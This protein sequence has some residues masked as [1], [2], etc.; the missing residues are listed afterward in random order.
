MIDHSGCTEWL[1]AGAS[2]GCHAFCGGCA[3]GRIQGNEVHTWGILPGRGTPHSRHPAVR[4]RASDGCGGLSGFGVC[5]RPGKS[6]S[7]TAPWRYGAQRGDQGRNA[8]AQRLG[9]PW[10]YDGDERRRVVKDVYGN[11][12]YT[13]VGLPASLHHLGF[14][15]RIGLGLFER[16]EASHS[17]STILLGDARGGREK[18]NA[19]RN[20]L[21]NN[22]TDACTRSGM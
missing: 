11:R 15:L 8:K 13:F 12:L 19:Q 17:I 1:W 22:N 4:L 3:G 7:R 14:R 10:W 6:V 2:E 16:K 9:P 5:H 20:K 21:R 18:K